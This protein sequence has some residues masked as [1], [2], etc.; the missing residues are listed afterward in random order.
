M[1]KSSHLKKDNWV[2]VSFYPEYND[3]YEKVFKDACWDYSQ[4]NYEVDEEIVRDNIDWN[5]THYFFIA[6]DSEYNIETFV[7]DVGCDFFD[8]DLDICWDIVEN[9][10]DNIQDTLFYI[11]D[12]D[13]GRWSKVDDEY[14]MLMF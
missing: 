4:D 8:R 11:Y 12:E 3:K 9:K 6:K 14:K 10:T 5:N 13:A 2:K 7:D 1:L